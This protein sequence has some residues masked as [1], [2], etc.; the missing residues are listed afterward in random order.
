ME[1]TDG[2]QVPQFSSASSSAESESPPSADGVDGVGDALPGD[3]LPTR[4]W[5]EF[6]T[7]PLWLPVRAAVFY[8][9]VALPVIC[10]ALTVFGPPQDPTW[11][12][13]ALSD[14]LAFLLSF[15]SGWPVLPFLAFSVICL[16]LVVFAEPRFGNQRVVRFGVFSGVPVSAWYAVIFSLTV[17]GLE[18]GVGFL[19]Y[20]FGSVG[21]IVVGWLA[22]QLLLWIR[23]K[24]RIRW[25]T[26]ICVVTPLLLMAWLGSA[27]YTSRHA[28]SRREFGEEFL[29]ALMVNLA[30]P[31]VGFLFI[32]LI[33]STYWCFSVY[34][35]MSFRLA[36][37]FPGVLRFRL[38]EM[39]LV[40]TW[41]AGLLAAW[42]W[43]IVLSLAEYA[44]LPVTAPETC[45][46]ASTAAK[47]H[48]RVVHSRPVQVHNG[49]GTR[50]ND[51]LA[52]LK[53]GELAIRA[54]MPG[55]H[56]RIRQVYDWLGPVIARRL[57]RYGMV[58]AGYYGLKPAEWLVSLALLA[59]LGKRSRL[60][61]ARLYR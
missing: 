5:R 14:K 18:S 56:R 29:E 50:V 54:L 31:F 19:L 35:G 3:A 23:R 9:G 47:G 11:Q 1:N 7:Q 39:M 15:D 60:W 36:L 24:L 52:T 45:Y 10:H 37:L 25:W 48:P 46:I 42:R 27:A 2:E 30:G 41:F 20:G 22:F 33:F 40:L 13:G 58:E 43:A 38:A 16:A 59:M 26:V 28:E 6:L 34:L 51:Q 32:S 61:L 4:S 12:S 44:K 8:A 55:C 17:G 53:A 57:Q 21:A 49:G